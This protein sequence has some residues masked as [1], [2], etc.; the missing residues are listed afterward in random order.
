MSHALL[1]AAVND[2]DVN[3]PGLTRRRVLHGTAL[4]ALGAALPA[5]S[6]PGT[7]PAR[8]DAA[9]PLALTVDATSPGHAVSPYLFG[10]FF[11]EINYGGVGGLY[12]E[13]LR[14][15]AFMD[16]ATPVQW[17]APADIPRV[18]G[19]FGSA[20]QLGAGSPV[21][22][23]QLPAGVV[24]ALT[25]FT[26]AAWVNPSSIATWNRVFD[27]GDGENVY[28]FLA[29]S[30]GS[31]PRFAI[32]V[33]SNGHEQQLNAPAVLPVNA[34][35][36]LAVSLSG[37]TATLY[38]NGT[39]VDTNTAM[40]LNP[41]SLGAT[42][43]NYIGKS[44]WPD[45]YFNATVDEFQIYSRALS[46]AEVQSLQTSAGGGAGGGDVAWYRFDEA[47]GSVAV[48][49]SGAGHDAVIELVTT[50]WSSV[51]DGGAQATAVIDATVPLNDQ[52]TR[53]LRL[54]LE[55]VT[56]GQRAAM[57]NGG[58]FGVPVVPGQTYR[59]SFFAKADKGFRGPV[60]LGLESADGTDVYATAE[61]G[62]VTRDW[63]QHSTILRVPHTAAAST[64]AR[65]VIGVDNRRGAAAH[66]PAGSS[67][68]LQVV[69]LFP[70]TYRD[71][72]NGLRPDLARLVEQIGPKIFRFPGGN[73]IEGTSLDTRFDWKKTVGPV[74]ER[75]GHQN[76]AWGYWSDDGLG[77]LEYLQFIEDIGATP[78]MAVWAGYTLSGSVV[79][80]ADLAP[81]V[82]DA[83]DQIEYAIGPATS[84]WGARRAA[85]GHPAPF[86]TPFVEIGNEDTFD[87]GGSYQ[88]YRYPM[89][90]DAIK[91]A[92]PDIKCIAT[93][94][95]TSRPMDI[96]DEHYYSDAAF[97]ESNS[98]RYDSY[99]RSGPQVFVGEYAATA[100]AGSLAT[101]LL[102]NSVGEAAFL[103]GLERNS[104]IVMMSSY[105]PLFANY[106]HTQ[107]NPDLIGY[108]QL[109]SYGST[110]YWVQRL[111][112][113]NLGD[114][115]LPVTAS[116][117]GLYCSATVDS[118]TGRIYLKIV[119][120]AAQAV[121]TQLT[122]SGRKGAAA[123]IEVLEGDDPTVGNTLADPDALVPSRTSLRGA[124]GVFDYRAPANSV[125]VVTLNGR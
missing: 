49:S 52:I 61:V 48:D 121:G 110:S 99:D 36:H 71:R 88:A 13:L 82:Q 26:V 10:A 118:R 75:P 34:W 59:V 84:K 64:A 122:F 77:L 97:F 3:R 14:N 25:D 111:F 124:G 22:F 45:P 51:S 15:R 109:Q 6:V 90:Y 69:S 20:V 89:F 24:G 63:K 16:P 116:A 19:K 94:P 33:Q 11:E 87:R 114:K 30:A 78:V 1:E 100:N 92:H 106:G 12:A 4:G 79:A 125:T 105:A 47:R 86:P 8:A 31:A 112:A 113:N 17:Y 95:V 76:S 60:T 98:T 27:F 46:A 56:A 28:M 42:T 58:Y 83:L 23:V 50:D 117:S 120:P 115:V 70:P 18:P 74:W 103:T 37:T 29:A 5:A 55:S 101:G 7:A 108:D 80:E 21:Q 41:K 65:F 9:D 44:Q 123:Q 68:W 73:Y 102:G 96:I 93:T 104:D 53:S 119:N 38:V 57:A 39:A 2:D 67:L 40:T 35:S 72:P 107:W 54:D 91:A 32:T 43:Q 62:G 66:V 85:D 81:Y